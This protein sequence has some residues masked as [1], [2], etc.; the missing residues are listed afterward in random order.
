MRHAVEILKDGHLFLATLY[1]VAM[2]GDDVMMYVINMQFMPS[3]LCSSGYDDAYPSASDYCGR[4][5]HGQSQSG[6]HQINWMLYGILYPSLNQGY[7][8]L[9]YEHFDQHAVM[10]SSL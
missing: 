5:M 9:W 3:S 8:T 4:V 7:E 10:P 2:L 6:S 1:V